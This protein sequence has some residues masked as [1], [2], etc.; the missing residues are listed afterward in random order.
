MDQGGKQGF[1]LEDSSNQP[2]CDR[3]IFAPGDKMEVPIAISWVSMG[4]FTVVSAEKA[5]F[6]GRALYAHGNAC[7]SLVINRS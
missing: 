1:A 6:A 5:C 2:R 3:A 4:S 7:G